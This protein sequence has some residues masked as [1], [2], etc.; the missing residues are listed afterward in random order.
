ME[1]LDITKIKEGF[2][3]PGVNYKLIEKIGG[4][5]DKGI[6]LAKD[7]SGTCFA[8][9][10]KL[11]RKKGTKAEGKQELT[12]S[13]LEDFF[14]KKSEGQIN[15]TTRTKVKGILEDNDSIMEQIDSIIE[16]KDL[17]RKEAKSFEKEYLEELI[18]KELTTN[19]VMGIGHTIK[20]AL[21]S[22]GS[23]TIT[24][25]DVKIPLL[26]SRS[27]EIDD[28]GKVSPFNIY[29]IAKNIY[30]LPVISFYY[31]D[32]KSGADRS[33]HLLNT[34]IIEKRGVLEFFRHVQRTA[35]KTGSYCPAFQVSDKST[36][37]GELIDL[38]K[39]LGNFELSKSN[40]KDYSSIIDK[41]TDFISEND[42]EE[43]SKPSLQECSIFL[44]GS[45]NRLSSASILTA[46][47]N[48]FNKAIEAAANPDKLNIPGF[49]FK[50]NVFID[51]SIKENKT[52]I[53]GF[54]NIGGDAILEGVSPT[55]AYGF[56]PNNMK[57][58]NFMPS[59]NVMVSIFKKRDIEDS[60]NSKETDIDEEVF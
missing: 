5:N 13:E 40:S 10:F 6:Y 34:K 35:I 36:A 41:I 19:Y 56:M 8:V 39:E 25:N 15:S 28:T 30:D 46:E 4:K 47:D 54:Y 21:S 32:K 55:K 20:S 44:P 22:N 27:I 16:E 33:T 29:Y 49:D 59:I 50:M 48:N 60:D 53:F 2:L 23:D 42:F 3:I 58:K 45:L 51:D 18:N 52:P 37:K 1:I 38:L 43:V 31:A 11:L 57:V 17:S 14:I 7:L 26:V 24:Y 9:Q 12:H